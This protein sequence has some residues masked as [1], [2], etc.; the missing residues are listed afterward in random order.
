M[1]WHSNLRQIADK[2]TYLRHHPLEEVRMV[3]EAIE[4][5]LCEALPSSFSR[6]RYP[7]TEVYVSKFMTSGYLFTDKSCPDFMLYHDGVNLAQLREYADELSQRP[8]RET[9]LP[10]YI[11]EC[12]YVQFKFLLDFGS[13]RD[14]QRH[15]AVTQ[16]MPL[17]TMHHGFEPWYI[18]QM[19]ERLSLKVMSSL[20]TLRC[21]VESLGL[22]ISVEEMQ[23]FT[24]MGYRLPNRLTGGLK[25]LV[26]LAERRA[27][28][29]VHPT[30]QIRAHQM[31]YELNDRFGSFGLTV[32]TDNDQGRFDISRGHQDIVRKDQG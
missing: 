1:A 28:K 10:W 6:K 16:R 21:E 32:H 14:I 9:E 22:D 26:Y 17:V 3:A 27:R 11:D 8:N 12:G 29:D 24:P 31:A 23:Y 4:D 5:A 2:L 15:R 7:E 19:P 18:E 30:L 13:F 20:E 25:A